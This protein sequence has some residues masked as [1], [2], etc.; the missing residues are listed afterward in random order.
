MSEPEPRSGTKTGERRRTMTEPE[1]RSGTKT[2]ERRRTMTAIVIVVLLAGSAHADW[3]DLQGAAWAHYE[4]SGVHDLDTGAMTAPKFEDL[5]LAG[6]RLHG[7]VSHSRIGWHIGLDAAAGATTRT[8][9]FAYD[10]AFL[11]VGFGIRFADTDMVG[12][13]AGVGAMGAVGTLD[14]AATFP[15]EAFTELAVGG[16]VRVLARARA[17]YLAG[18]PGRGGGSRTLSF[19]DEVDGMLALRIG[20]SYHEYGFPSGNG[21]FFGVAYRELL[22]VRFAGLILG[23]SID[24]ATRHRHDRYE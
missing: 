22:G 1:P 6:L 11:P 14:D 9:G 2:G 20:H 13:G 15:I 8:A 3:Q 19:V 4:L 12:L 21:Y 18:A 5:T 10:V 7:F 16:H 24:I 23:Y 17:T